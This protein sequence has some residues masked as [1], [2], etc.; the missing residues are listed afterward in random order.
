MRL[1]IAVF[2]SMVLCHCAQADAWKIT[3]RGHHSAWVV[4]ESGTTESPPA[5]AVTETVEKVCADALAEVNA[6]RAKRGLP[7][8]KADPLLAQAAYECAKIRAASHIHGHLDSDH[9]RLP[10]GVNRS[11]I[12]SGCGALEPSWGWGTCCTYDDYTHAGAALVMGNDGRRYMHLFVR[13]EKT[14]TPQPRSE[15]VFGESVGDCSNGSCSSGSCSARWA[16]GG[17]I[18]RGRRGR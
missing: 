14:A 6:E 11:A 9:D 2:A 17:I 16:P 5:K 13:N 3:S 4:T 1:G 8:F 12:V 10:A 15:P 18:T 7:A